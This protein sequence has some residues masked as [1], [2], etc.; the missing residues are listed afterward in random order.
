MTI[1]KK[2]RTKKNKLSSSITKNE[3]KAISALDKLMSASNLLNI[4]THERKNKERKNEESAVRGLDKLIGVSSLLNIGQS[5]TKKTLE[6]AS[7]ILN[8]ISK[9]K[10]KNGGKNNKTNKKRVKNKSRKNKK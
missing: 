1:V 10:N 7:K 2:P 8:T 4:K 3:K 6:N 9:N 5:K